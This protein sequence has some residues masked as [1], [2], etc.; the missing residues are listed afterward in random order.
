MTTA[1]F[2]EL[3]RA[4]LFA[5]D[6]VAWERLRVEEWVFGRGIPVN[7]VEPSSA[8]FAATRAAAE[9]FV[10]SGSTQGVSGDWLTVEWL[11]FLGALPKP[12][13]SGQMA[14]LDRRFGLTARGNSEV[15]FAWLEH[16]VAADYEPAFPALEH[17]L[18]SQGRRK[19][20][21]PLYEQMDARATTH[22]LAR[23]IYAKARPRYHPI[24][25]T[26]LD[27]LLKW[28]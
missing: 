18:T 7:L 24:A 13:S 6:P 25:V 12:L 5:N 8:R 20:L 15:L 14:E 1:R 16:A 9:A 22:A 21:T 2:L 11:D 4:G 26:T 23:R 27:A 3:L 17:F 19:F 10:K 28:Q